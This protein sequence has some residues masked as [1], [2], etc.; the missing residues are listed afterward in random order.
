MNTVCLAIFLIVN[1]IW[2]WYEGTTWNANAP[3]RK[4]I[5]YLMGTSSICIALIMLGFHFGYIIKT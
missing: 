3:L 5:C 2:M 4:I 1:G